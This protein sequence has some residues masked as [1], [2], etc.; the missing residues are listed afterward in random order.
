[1]A[2]KDSDRDDPRLEHEQGIS[3]REF[4]CGEDGDFG[5]GDVHG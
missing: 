3:R 4:H 2:K 5:G 1:M